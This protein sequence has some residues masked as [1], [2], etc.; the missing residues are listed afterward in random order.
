[1]ENVLYFPPQK[2]HNCTHNACLYMIDMP[3]DAKSNRLLLVYGEAGCA[4][5]YESAIASRE[6]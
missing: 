4:V 3:R 6:I 2:N 1:M 5:V